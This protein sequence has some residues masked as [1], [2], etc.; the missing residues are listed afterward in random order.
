MRKFLTAISILLFINAIVLLIRT[1]F[2]FTG[3]TLLLNTGILAAV[4]CYTILYDNLIKIKLLNILI[5]LFAFIYAALAVFALSYGKRNTA[6]FQEDIAIVLGAGLR[7]DD[8]VTRSLQN[9]LDTA[10]YYHFRNPYAYIVVSGGVGAGRQISE[11]EAMARYLKDNGVY[12]NI[13][14]LE[15]RSH[16]TYQNMRFSSLLLAEQYNINISDISV[17]VITNEFH[18]YRGIWFA[19]NAG[20]NNITSLYA[21]TPL[22][23]LPGALVREA[24]AI[25]KMWLTET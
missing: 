16:S 7:H 9:R 6:T 5:L 20:F 13:I 4:V 1:D 23:S 11:A 3:N 8:T 19:E 24:A 14:I 15:D 10:V 2:H 22:L 12:V 17:V 18:I 25:V 21:Q